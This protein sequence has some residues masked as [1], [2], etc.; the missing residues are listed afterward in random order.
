MHGRLD[1]L[2]KYKYSQHQQYNC[3]VFVV[4]GDEV[5]WYDV[6][7]SSSL[8]S[9]Q[10]ATMSENRFQRR[11]I[12]AFLSAQDCKSYVWRGRH[13]MQ[14]TVISM[15][16]STVELYLHD[17]SWGEGYTN[18]ADDPNELIHNWYNSA[19]NTHI[20]TPTVNGQC[21]N[22]SSIENIWALLWKLFGC[23]NNWDQMR[24]VFVTQPIR[25]ESLQSSGFCLDAIVF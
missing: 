18:T 14:L 5:C 19:L 17:Y 25:A 7:I 24:R 9:G 12:L 4:I 6:N 10:A 16:S 1:L 20:I 13:L 21:E 15:T 3:T 8:C 23:K 11:P 22:M 2:Y